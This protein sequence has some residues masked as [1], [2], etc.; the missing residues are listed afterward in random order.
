MKQQ[1]KS[2]NIR[3]IYTTFSCFWHVVKTSPCLYFVFLQ[4]VDLN[5]QNEQTDQK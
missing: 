1:F 3:Q 2:M 4:L 5:L